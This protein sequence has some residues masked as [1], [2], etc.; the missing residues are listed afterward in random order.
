MS[1]IAAGTT[2]TT[3]YV[4]SSD[5]TG[6][7]VLKTGASATTAVTIGSDQS[8]TFVGS[9]T[10]SAG[11]ANGVLYLNGSK[12]ATSGSALV[13]DGTNLGIGTASPTQKLYVAGNGLFEAGFT[14]WTAT[15]ST[16]GSTAPAIWSP[17]SGVMGLWANGAERA[18]IDSSGNFGIGTSSPSSRLHATSTTG[19]IA[20][21][22]GSGTT[23]GAADTGAALMF[24]GSDGSAV[25]NFAQISGYKENGTSG[26]YATY[27]AFSTRANGGSITERAR[28]D[29]SGNFG[30][31]TTSP[32]ASGQSSGI[33]A[34]TV[35][36][37]K[38]PLT[39]HTTSAGIFEYN[40]NKITIRAYGATAGSGHIAFNVGGGGGSADF[41]AARIT[42]DGD[43][44]I[45]A[46]SQAFS[47]GYRLGIQSGGT[48]TFF[49]IAKAGQ[50]LGSGGM[51]I[52]IDGT[53]GALYVRENQPFD[54]YTN[55][56][57]RVRIASTG[58][59]LVGKSS[60]DIGTNGWSLDPNGGGQTFTISSGT[61]EAFTWNNVSTGGT[62]QLD[63]R[64][65]NV[66]KG[67]ISW[68][69]SSTSYN[70]ASDY[71]LKENIAPMTGALAR[72][73]QLKPVT[74]TWKADGSAGEGFVAHDLAEVCPQAVTGEKDAVRE[75]GVT[76][77]YQ[78]ID[79]SFLVATLTA[80][81]QEQQAIIQQ[82]QAD[83]SALKGTA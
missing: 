45:G 57:F 58:A 2:T 16:P 3:G 26:N 13:F 50:T 66:E 67:N 65:A 33:T 42:S 41:E 43:L 37:T 31:G 19:V 27:L 59:F 12:V 32:V 23:S 62:A 64:T 22:D 72:V 74:Y 18:R 78:G 10:L 81:I 53:G 14:Y 83:V 73:A 36:A 25:R 44:L 82:L 47:A 77:R 1:S 38:G 60:A 49:G 76:P 71:R 39:A 21:L 68:N 70:T 15:G 8:V 29:A 17:A 56:A 5:T 80:A 61:N 48:Q 54:F 63:F 34:N 51:I 7:L 30:V 4:V 11:T 52:G 55:N 40:T 79:T 9:Q 69:N 6:A 20:T 46:S 24:N 28:I 35:V 75:D